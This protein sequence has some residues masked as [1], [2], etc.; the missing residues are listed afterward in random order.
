MSVP[1]KIS[2]IFGGRKSTI[3]RAFEA[4]LER[5]DTEY[6]LIVIDQQPNLAKKVERS[7]HGEDSF[8]MAA[9][10]S[11]NTEVCNSLLANG[12]K[13]NVPL[14]FA[15]DTETAIS[16]VMSSGYQHPDV[17]NA[18]LEHYKMHAETEKSAG[19][20]DQLKTKTA[21]LFKSISDKL[22]NIIK[23]PGIAFTGMS[24]PTA[25]IGTVLGGVAAGA[26]VGV[27]GP[28]AVGVSAVG[29]GLAAISSIRANNIEAQDHDRLIE[30]EKSFKSLAEHHIS[31]QLSNSAETSRDDNKVVAVSQVFAEQFV[32]NSGQEVKA[33]NTAQGRYAGPLIH[34]TERHVVQDLGRGSV[35]VHSKDHIDHRL[36]QSAL[37][38][39]RSTKIQYKDGRAIVESGVGQSQSQG[40]SR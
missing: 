13:I 27:L 19:L 37:Q 10:R 1:D 18:L 39:A 21:G 31:R 38:H 34:Q 22:D 25:A 12:A 29:V 24:M 36:I 16:A 33:V 11:G 14:R 32:E 6:C 30:A 15:G 7:V 5:G 3:M 20:L 35:A 8:L 40:H 28:A 23:Q 26:S 2:D 17:R 9:I 4:A